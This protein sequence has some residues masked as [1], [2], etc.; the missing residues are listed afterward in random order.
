MLYPL[1]VG[2]VIRLNSRACTAPAFVPAT[3]L[4]YS[5]LDYP[6]NGRRRMGRASV[7]DYLRLPV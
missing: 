4:V 6:E 3:Q 2:P 7:P 5:P 1:S